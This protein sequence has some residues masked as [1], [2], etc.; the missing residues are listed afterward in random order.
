MKLQNKVISEYC[1]HDLEL[2]VNE[3]LASMDASMVVD[4]K[5]FDCEGSVFCQI[6]YLEENNNNEKKEGRRES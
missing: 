3:F 5:P 4:I 6:I 2:G 1:F